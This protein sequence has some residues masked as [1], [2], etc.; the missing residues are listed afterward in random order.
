MVRSIPRGGAAVVAAAWVVAGV[1]HACSGGGWIAVAFA[2]VALVGSVL[3]VSAPRPELLILAAVAGAAAVA[4]FAV[5]FVLK[6]L[7]LGVATSDPRDLWGIGAFLADALT[8][9]LAVFTLR[10]A[11][12]SGNGEPS[13]RSPERIT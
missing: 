4:V 6:V 2:V 9:R 1:L 5:P 10:R 13:P 11:N 3:L 7:G 8:V 12:R